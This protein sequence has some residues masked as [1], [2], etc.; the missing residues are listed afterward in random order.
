MAVAMV[1]YGVRLWGQ[2][3]ATGRMEPDAVM[4]WLL[5]MLAA[6]M[7]ARMALFAR[8]YHFGFFQAALAGMV[9]VAIMVSEIPRW[10]GPGRVGRR[11]AAVGGFIVLTLGCGSIAA[12]SNAVRAEETQ[13]VGTEADRFYA[14]NRDI[15]PTASL[16]DWV[17]KALSAAPPAGA[18]M[19]LPDGQAI[20]FL[21]RRVSP[22]PNVWASGT[23]ESKVERLR[24]A[25]PEFVALISV[26]LNEHD[27]PQYG[28]PGKP[29]W[30]FL[31]WVHQNYTEVISC[32]EPFS[33]TRL[34]G[35]SILRRNHDATT[36]Q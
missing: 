26:D 30:F 6:A 11:V 25:P 14:F 35:A 10:T 2:W 19:V 28:A 3:R 22:L 27:I 16:V 21:T 18:L 36:P 9:A 32:G 13:P 15:D 4:Q 23:E 17:V 12:Q 24:K 31:Q 8:V 5:A 34:K 20:N 1:F 7:L 29:G 33:G